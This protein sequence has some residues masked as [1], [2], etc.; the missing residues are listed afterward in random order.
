MEN[1]FITQANRFIAKHQRN[2]ALPCFNQKS[3]HRFAWRAQDWPDVAL[4]CR[5]RNNE[6]GT[7]QGLLQ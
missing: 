4:T 3:C 5:E 7:D 2:L 1:F 6:R